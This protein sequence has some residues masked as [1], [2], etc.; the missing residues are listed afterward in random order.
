MDSRIRIRS[1]QT[2][3]S[4]PIVAEN[5]AGFLMARAIR[6]VAYPGAVNSRYAERASGMII[7]SGL[8]CRFLAP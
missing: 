4:P 3:C 8:V 6:S 1:V 7:W 2:R 5:G